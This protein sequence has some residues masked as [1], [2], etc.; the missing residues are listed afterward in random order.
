MHLTCYAARKWFNNKTFASFQTTFHVSWSI[1]CCAIFAVL[2]WLQWL[3]WHKTY[4]QTKIESPLA[5]KKESPLCYVIILQHS[6]I[7]VNR[8]FTGHKHTFCVRPVLNHSKSE[9][10]CKR[11]IKSHEMATFFSTIKLTT[12]NRNEIY[13]DRQWDRCSC[14]R[15]ENHVLNVTHTTIKSFVKIYAT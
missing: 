12:W 6:Y 3:Q 15:N 13:T 4:T 5:I 8:C 2:Q 1:N 7:G 14:N 10:R 9:F 11:L